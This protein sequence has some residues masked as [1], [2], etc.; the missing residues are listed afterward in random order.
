MRRR[1]C[2]YFFCPFDFFPFLKFYAS[3]VDVQCYDNLCCTTK[4]FSYTHPFCDHLYGKRMGKRIDE[5]L[6]LKQLQ[7]WWKEE[8]EELIQPDGDQRHTTAKYNIGS[9]TG[10]CT[11]GEEYFFFSLSLS[12]KHI[13]G[14]SGKYWKDL[15]IRISYYINVNFLIWILTLIM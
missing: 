2:L 12:L 3:I 13:I 15:W 5:A 10:F 11:K 6:P 9:W 1:H 14:T 7:K 8:D 4:G